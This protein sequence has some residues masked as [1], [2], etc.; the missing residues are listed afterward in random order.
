MPEP[1]PLGLPYNGALGVGTLRGLP[2]MLIGS[3]SPLALESSPPA[4]ASDAQTP[5]SHSAVGKQINR[6]CSLKDKEDLC[7]LT[8]I[9]PIIDVRSALSFFVSALTPPPPISQTLSRAE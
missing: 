4:A 1:S 2:P 8:L 5:S 3:C 6:L 7:R 9:H